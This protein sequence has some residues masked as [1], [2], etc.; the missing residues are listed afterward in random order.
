MFV[1]AACRR[2]Q[3]PLVMVP[4]DIADEQDCEGGIGV[5][6]LLDLGDDG[7]AVVAEELFDETGG[8]ALPNGKRLIER[9]DGEDKVPGFNW[10]FAYEVVDLAEGP[11]E[12]V[13]FGSV[14]RRGLEGDPGFC[15]SCAIVAGHGVTSPVEIAAK[16]S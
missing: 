7:F 5:G 4:F 8:E 2:F 15:Q 11:E 12:G 6:L 13:V 16:I 9:P 3:T 14:L 10:V 1:H